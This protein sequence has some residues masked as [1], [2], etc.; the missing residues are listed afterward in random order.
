MTLSARQSRDAQ[1]SDG[2]TLSASQQ[3]ALPLPF[4]ESVSVSR[5]TPYSVE[6][7]RSITFGSLASFRLPPIAESGSLITWSPVR[8]EFGDWTIRELDI[9]PNI[10]DLLHGPLARMEGHYREGHRGYE[11]VVRWNGK[12]VM[13]TVHFA[14]VCPQNCAREL[15]DADDL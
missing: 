5:S 15:A 4:N 3:R 13:S 2:M 8:G 7:F 10:D 9:I 14:K 11:L 6:W 12:D 1:A